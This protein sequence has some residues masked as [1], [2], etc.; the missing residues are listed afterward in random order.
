MG[1]GFTEDEAN[2]KRLRKEN[3]V[4]QSLYCIYQLI[5]RKWKSTMQ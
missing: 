5:C 3:G 2:K 1:G 4:S